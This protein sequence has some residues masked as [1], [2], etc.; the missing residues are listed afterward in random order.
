[1]SQHENFKLYKNKNDEININ[2]NNK[3]ISELYY[4]I[5]I[6]ESIISNI[7]NKE[8]EEEIKNLLNKI[9]SIFTKLKSDFNQIENLKRK[10]EQIIRNLYGKYFNINMIKESLEFKNDNLLKKE[11]EYEMLKEKTGAIFV[12]GKI[13]CNERK[14][15]EIIILKTENS[16]LKNEIKNNEDLLSEKNNI[17][18]HLNKQIEELNKKIEVFDKIKDGKYSSFSNININI[19]GAKEN[20]DNNNLKNLRNKSP[21]FVNSINVFSSNKN[22]NE[23]INSENII[24]SCQLNE[25]LMNKINKNQNNANKD[26]KEILENNKYTKKYIEV[27]KSLFSAKSRTK[28]KNVL[29]IN[30]IKRNISNNNISKKEC[31]SEFTENI[32]GE[33]FNINHNKNSNINYSGKIFKTIQNI[34]SQINSNKNYLKHKKIH[35][36]LTESRNHYNNF[37]YLRLGNKNKSKEN[38]SKNNSNSL[39]SSIIFSLTKNSKKQVNKLDIIKDYMIPYTNRR[40]YKRRNNKIIN[41]YI[42]DNSFNLMQ[43]SFL[44]KINVEKNLNQ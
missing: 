20:N 21:S 12:N 44:T 25:K 31:V 43:N 26:K 24:S 8:I 11:K 17:I 29:Q 27:N 3:D 1:M 14:D 22:I 35:S 19:N 9:I 23:N 18:N 40:N 2:S 5:N 13:I 42:K 4:T 15:N 16:L 7:K 34:P 39:P 38:N 6:I 10:D 28:N 37:Q 41:N 30:K 32:G 36:L 33:K